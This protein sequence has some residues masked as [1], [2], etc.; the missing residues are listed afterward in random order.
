MTGLANARP[1]DDGRHIERRPRNLPRRRLMAA[2]V[3]DGVAVAQQTYFGLSERVKRLAALA[4][5]PGLAAVQ[6]GEDAASQVYVRNK[7]RA[8]AVAGLHSEVHHHTADCTEPAVL[9]TI[10][11]LNANPAIHGI[12]VQLPLPPQ[13]DP[14]R[15]TQAILPGKDVDGFNWLNLGALVAGRAPFEP[16]TPR[17]V[18]A[19]LDH[20]GLKLAGSHAVIVGRSAIVGKPTAL[21]LLNRGATVTICHTRTR[22][23]ARHTI[24]ADILVAAAGRAGLITASMV[25]AGAA[26]IDVGIN[27]N[28]AGRLVGD[29]D[30][31]GVREVAGWITPVPGGVGPMT[32]AMLIA[33][34][35][36][37]AERSAG[38]AP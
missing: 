37:A 16:C 20:A 24:D 26:V 28:P 21:L 9:E 25:K 30:F 35:V 33:N 11:R 23:L 18:V 36:L 10:A 4:I 38:L 29:V 15:I 5:R 3:I 7:M 19:L 34:T 22:D 13:L 17:G 1:A 14:A 32:V 31:P 8:C 2:T 27:R 12:L 6:F